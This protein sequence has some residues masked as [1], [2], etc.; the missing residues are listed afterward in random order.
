[1]KRELEMLK[2]DARAVSVECFSNIE[3]T[4]TSA[5]YVIVATVPAAL[6]LDE[7]RE[8]VD[9]IFRMDITGAYDC[10]GQWFSNGLGLVL[11]ST[12]ESDGET[13][14]DAYITVSYGVDI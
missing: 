9:D 6:D 4:A 2:Q 5:G 1:M 10:T 13:V 11:G 14:R 12:Y 8:I 7:L 3:N